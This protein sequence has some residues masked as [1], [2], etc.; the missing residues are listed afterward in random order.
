M[1][2]PARKRTLTLLTNPFILAAIPTLALLFSIP[3]INQPYILDLASTARIAENH[4]LSYH[5][6]D[7]DGNSEKIDAFDYPNGSGITIS[8]NGRILN[9]W[10]IEGTFGFSGKVTLNIPADCNG[11]G[12]RELYLFSIN[13]VSI[14]LHSVPDPTDPG[15]GV[16]NRLIDV[17]GRGRNAPDPLIVKAEPQDLDGDGK[18][19]LLFGITSG[20]S[21]YPRKIYAYY[22]ARD[23]LVSSPQLGGF[24][25]GIIQKDINNDGFR[26]LMP[27][28]YASGNI[29]PSEM[30]YHDISAWLTVLDRNLEFLFEPKEY[31]GNLALVVPMISDSPGNQKPDF[32][33]SSL[34]K[35]SLASLLSFDV[36]GETSNRAVIGVIPYSGFVTVNGKKEPVYAVLERD[37]GI[38]L[39]NREGKYLKEFG[40]EGSP[41]VIQS[42]IDLDGSQEIVVSSYETGKVYV[43]RAGLRKPAVA[44]LGRDFGGELLFSVIK[45]RN[46]APRIYLQTGT[47]QFRIEYRRNPLYFLSF[48]LHPLIYAAFIAF[49]LLIQ[50]AQKRVLTR[51]E[52]QRR[53]ISELQLSLIGN[54]LD[55]HFTLNALNSVLHL[56][57]QS[58]REKLRSSLQTFS[59]LYRDMLLSAGKPRRTLA[60]EIEFCREYLALEKMRFGERFDYSVVL[61][62]EINT[63]LPLPKFVIQLFAENSV[64]H[65]IASRESGG[66]LEITVRAEERVLTIDI[67]DN[68]I[69]RARSAGEHTGT[70]GKGMKLMT[71]LF[72]LCNRYYED[73]HSF[74]VTDLSDGDGQP[75]GTQV[76]VSIRYRN[77]DV[78]IT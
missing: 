51:R 75:A 58:D 73:K 52:E 41:T 55:P 21:K 48:V 16:S 70:T 63:E 6:L 23:S 47:S 26:E 67:R 27:L 38:V 72:D 60:E 1:V 69:G 10:N 12:I 30:K 22:P 7:G 61:P 13:G 2:T 4:Y 44:D 9:Q 33:V 43:F 59:G 42:D 15:F 29:D 65:G 34:E 3:V 76:T 35:D 11:D 14:L 40:M 56:V 37:R 74:T 24:I 64:K 8:E 17:A 54:Q 20:F 78:I 46:E 66:I 57:E 77:Q 45:A 36:S 39:F 25:L 19:E 53:R 18:E 50:G 28:N 68:G 31:K 5:D 62:E 71:E 49:V 32:L